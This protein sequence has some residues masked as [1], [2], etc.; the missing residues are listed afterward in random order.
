MNLIVNGLVAFRGVATRT[1]GTLVRTLK[2]RAQKI[3]KMNKFFPLDP[4]SLS[5]ETK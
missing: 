2:S 1:H 4:M 5:R 3:Y